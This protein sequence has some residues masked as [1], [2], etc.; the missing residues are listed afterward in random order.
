M[1]RKEFYRHDYFSQCPVFG[2]DGNTKQAGYWQTVSLQGGI[3]VPV[4]AIL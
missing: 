2:Y 3:T 4:S 1:L